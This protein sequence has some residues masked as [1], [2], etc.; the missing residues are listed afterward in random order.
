MKSMSDHE[1]WMKCGNCGYTW[2]I[3]GNLTCPICATAHLPEDAYQQWLIAKQDMFD[4][5]EIGPEARPALFEAALWF[6]G[7][8]VEIPMG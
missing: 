3:I 1:K 6:A 5:L 4:R 8:N 7:V 2:R